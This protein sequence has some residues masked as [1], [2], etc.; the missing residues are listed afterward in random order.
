MA[1]LSSTHQRCASFLRCKQH[2][3]Y[4]QKHYIETTHNNAGMLLIYCMYCYSLPYSVYVRQHLAVAVL[5]LSLHGPPTT[6]TTAQFHP[7]LP[8]GINKSICSRIATYIHT[9]VCTGLK[10][11]YIN[12][13]IILSMHISIIIL[14]MYISASLQQ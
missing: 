11:R 4:I 8:K 3:C 14:H 10:C 2:F 12:N 1:V 9:T 6:Q 5:L 13:Q 7:S